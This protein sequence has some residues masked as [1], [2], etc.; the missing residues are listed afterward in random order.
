MGL[1]RCNGQDFLYSHT[2]TPLRGL[3]SITPGEKQALPSANRLS[4]KCTQ[5][6]T[7]PKNLFPSFLHQRNR[8][9]LEWR[10]RK[11]RVFGKEGSLREMTQGRILILL[12]FAGRRRIIIPCSF[13]L[14]REENS[15]CCLLQIFRVQLFF[16][17]AFDVVATSPTQCSY[18]SIRPATE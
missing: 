18:P 4:L 13:V 6:I 16:A 11:V 12:C 15:F 3:N 17:A 10:Q 7:P 1:P 8:I 9:S 14:K 2:H 5:R